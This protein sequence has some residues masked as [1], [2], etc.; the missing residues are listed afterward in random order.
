[1]SATIILRT[2]STPP[3][4]QDIAGK[5]HAMSGGMDCVYTI[6]VEEVN[7]AHCSTDDHVIFLR[8][9]S[10][11][12]SFENWKCGPDVCRKLWK[13]RIAPRQ[14]SSLMH[15]ANIAW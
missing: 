14:I 9:N 1:M 5:Q 3:K 7:F 10:E 13:L 15:N 12:L 8:I 4:L 11:K 6:C 2:V